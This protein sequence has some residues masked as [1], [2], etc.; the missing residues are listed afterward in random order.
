MLICR[1]F[2]MLFSKKYFQVHT[3][4][5]VLHY[6]LKAVLFQIIKSL[7]EAVKLIFQNSIIIKPYFKGSN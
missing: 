7:L 6:F 2:Y 4:I 3:D 1:W 5:E